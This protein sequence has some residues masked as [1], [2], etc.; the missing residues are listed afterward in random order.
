VFDRIIAFSLRNR[1][2]V[3]AAAALVMVYGTY[4]LVSLPV[5]VLPD[6][7]RPTVTLL[8]EAEGLAPEEVETLV[9]LPVEQA[10]NGAPDVERVRSV[11]GIGLSVVYVEFDWGTDI[12]RARQLVSERLPQVAL[13]EGVTPTMGPITSVMGQIMLVGLTTRPGADPARADSA[14]TDALA[15]RDLAEWVVRPRLMTIS[16]VSNVI[17]IGGGLRQ[18]QVRPDPAKLLA[19]GLTLED[20]EGALRGSTANATG[21]YLDARGEESLVRVIGRTTS[22]EEIGRTVIRAPGGASLTV[23]DVAEVGYGPAPRRGDAGVN[24]RPGVILS[25][26]K[27]PGANT[28]ALT[29][30]IERALDEVEAGLPDNVALNRAVFRQAPFIEAAIGNV[31][32]AL[33]DGAILVVLVLFLFLLNFRT[34]AIT[35]TAIPLSIVISALVFKAFDV[36][37]NTMTLGGLAVAIGEL[38]DDAIVD[39]ENVFRRLRENAKAGYPKPALQVIRDA[40]SEVRS[41]IVFA[42]ILIV[43]VFLPLFALGGIE[44]RIFAPLGVAYITSILAS[45]LVALTVTPALCAYLLPNA[46]AITAREHDGWLVRKLKAADEWLLRRAL[47]HPEAVMGGAGV[48]VLA[49]LLTVPFLGREFLPPF[50]EGSFTV[51]VTL[52]PGTSLDESVRVGT[53]A[54]RQLLGVDGVTSTGR[55]T[56][57][58]ERDE[59]AEGVHYNE[60]DVEIAERDDRDQEAILAG[61]REALA[62]L[63]GASV[64]IGRPIGHRLDHLLSGVRAQV[65]VKVFG[66]DLATLREK[67]AEVQAAMAGVPGVVDLSVERQVLIPQVRVEVDREAARL[68]GARVADVNAAVGTAFAGEAVAEVT[69]GQRQYD[70][71]VRYPEGARED[72]A[73]LAAVLVPTEGGGQVPLASVA[74]VVEAYGPNQIARENVRRRIVVQAN[75]QGRDLGSAVEEAQ[76]R[77]AERVAMPAGYFV[78]FGGQ[79]ESQQAATRLIALLSLFSLAGMVLVLYVHFR[80]GRIVA[81]VLLNIPLALIGSVAALFLTTGTLSI[82]SLVGF[83]TLTGIASRN[84]IMMIS[85]YLH[86]VREEGEAF[87]EHMIIRGSLE[88]LVPVLMTAITAGLALV[89]LVLSAGEPGKE[90]LYPVA[91]VILGGLVSSTLLDIVVTPVVF[92]RYGRPALA[93]YLA[94]HGGDD[95]LAPSGDGLVPGHPWPA[96]RREPAAGAA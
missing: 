69:E 7:N 15:L 73:A 31:E 61:M 30:E 66:D 43:L 26:E 38:V 49:A 9:S 44:G 94:E 22:P 21:G 17:A 42:T 40:S 39:V 82:A 4:V 75:V 51:N 77:V 34:T 45:L 29:E 93:Q 32:E 74:R 18:Y 57:R 24:G 95:A 8:T 79:Y 65:A 53:L 78:E 6:L 50:N 83:I 59:H 71:V 55:R 56:G 90:I 16:G 14:G 46:K 3:V 10:M 19:F 5:D 60:I 88:R 80:S 92:W 64:S 37:I 85:H 33:R 67:A 20:V 52:P 2:L 72:P 23:A 48:L 96:E 89:P 28:V 68:Y 36:T 91:V 70:L 63:P 87:T 27:Q 41:S 81:Q 11:S 1:L 58:A 62:G 54:E 76:A 47:R 84:G 13:P 86:L 35:L 12:Y 25:V